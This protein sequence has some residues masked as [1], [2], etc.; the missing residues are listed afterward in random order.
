M[1]KEKILIVAHP[2]D[3]IIFFSSILKSVDKIL[4]CFGKSSDNDIIS[5]G[6]KSLQKNYPLTNIEWLNLNETDTYQASNWDKPIPTEDGLEVNRNK[7]AYREMYDDLCKILKN[8]IAPY[9]IV[10]THNPWGEYGHEEHVCIFN[11]VQS[12]MKG[13]SKKLY[14]SCYAS[15]RSE[16]LYLIK[17][18]L[19]ND[20][21]QEAKVPKELCYEIKNLY[22]E[23]NCW[24]WDN[25]YEWPNLEFFIEVG[26]FEFKNI[27]N[28]NTSNIESSIIVLSKKY[29]KNIL[30]SI[31]SKII[32]KPI[33]SIFN[34]KY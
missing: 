5:Q 2:D 26:N 22:L 8:K 33:K 10:Y 32:L 28:I 34:K 25:N 12:S 29:K 19:L 20:E 1:K 16:K 18:H 31:L 30:R 17:K 6:R 21:I 14:V 15:D 24:T 23:N 4:V 13:F 9:D 11:S 27:D 7:I 3:E